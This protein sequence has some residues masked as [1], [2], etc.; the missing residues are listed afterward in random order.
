MALVIL[1]TTSVVGQNFNTAS[2]IDFFANVASRLLSSEMNLNLT[3]I[4]I[5]PTTLTHAARRPRL[6]KSHFID[7]TTTNFY[8]SVF[9]PTFNVTLEN[10][11][12]NVY[13]NGYEQVASVTG[14]SDPQF[15]L[16]VNATDL[17]SDFGFGTFTNVN[18]YGI[19]W[20]IG[21]KKGQFNNRLRWRAPSS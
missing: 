20:I 13:I 21:V 3:R 7:A 10:G 6:L 15:D 1:T 12:T 4:E 8:P 14:T 16:P 2:P 11:N 9:R 19:P 18:V 5:Y 17:A